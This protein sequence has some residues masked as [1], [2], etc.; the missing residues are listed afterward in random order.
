MSVV[1]AWFPDYGHIVAGIF[2]IIA[3]QIIF[4]FYSTVVQV[5]NLTF[6]CKQEQRDKCQPATAL[7]LSTIFVSSLFSTKFGFHFDDKPIIH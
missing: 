3:M 6:T 1:V 7:L 5:Q 2:F 4:F